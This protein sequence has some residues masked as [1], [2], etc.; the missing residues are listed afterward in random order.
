[1]NNDVKYY[2]V[3]LKNIFLADSKRDLHFAVCDQGKYYDLLTNKEIYMVDNN[4]IN[5]EEFI[6][7]N[8]K[9]IGIEKQECSAAK[10]S[11]FLR[12]MTETSKNFLIEEV[13]NMENSIKESLNNNDFIVENKV[14]KIKKEEFL[15]NY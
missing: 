15:K 2:I 8:C 13:N 1:M 10:V 6:N 12:F 7:S 14:K 4:Y 11:L 3:T 5:K 9:L